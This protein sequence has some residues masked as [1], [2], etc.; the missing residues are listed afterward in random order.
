MAIR[1]AERGF[2]SRSAARRAHRRRAA[3]TWPFVLL[4]LAAAG[5]HRGGGAPAAAPPFGP[6]EIAEA[7]LSAG[8]PDAAV[9]A[10]EAYLAATPDGVAADRALFQLGLLY[11]LGEGGIGDPAAGR[12]R[13]R[14]LAERFPASP[15]A[16]HARSLLELME[17][18]DRLRGEV[19]RQRQV[20]DQLKKDLEALKRIDL[21]GQQPR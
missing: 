18:I 19:R 7:A 4:A 13:L 14:S 20:A 11:S 9:S 8:E 15:Y 5:C 16:L 12:A 2:R 17:E 10:Y 6:L 3:A 1:R 21:G